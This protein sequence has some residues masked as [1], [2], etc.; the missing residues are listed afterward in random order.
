M[1]NN[2]QVEE[3][4]LDPKDRQLNKSL[5]LNPPRNKAK[6]ISIDDRNG[7]DSHLIRDNFNNRRQMLK[8]VT[9]KN[10]SQKRSISVKKID[11]FNIDVKKDSQSGYWKNLVNKKW[12]SLKCRNVPLPKISSLKIFKRRLRT[13]ANSKSKDSINTQTTEHNRIS[14]PKIKPSRSVSSLNHRPWNSM[15][16]YKY[17]EGGKEYV[18]T[19]KSKKI[20]MNPL[21]LN[22]LVG[23]QRNYLL[24]NELI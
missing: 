8:K 22:I 5:M 15:D 6:R 3:V 10:N 20:R 19:K 1:G 11:G 24:D 21:A 23:E 17:T 4:E 14:L 18:G 2:A 7:I 9:N 12:D 16:V 13:E